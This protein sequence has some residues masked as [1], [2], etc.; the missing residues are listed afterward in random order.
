MK[1]TIVKCTQEMVA[2]RFGEH[3]WSEVLKRAGLPKWRN[4]LNFEDVSDSEFALLI[5]SIAHVTGLSENQV[6]DAHGEYWSTIYAPRVYKRY[7]EKAH[8]ARELLLQLDT[9]HWEMTRSMESAR[10]PNFTYE[11]Q[12][13]SC[14][15]MHYHSP[16]GLVM[17][18]AGLVRGVGK[19]YNENLT[20]K[21]VGNKVFVIFPSDAEPDQSTHSRSVA[22]H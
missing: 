10:P 17:L 7:F 21:V 12:N 19:Y 11:W 4:F 22:R 13:D 9:I 18:M 6:M 8:T 1:G 20:V 2:S 14:L 5:K 15:V 16:R 3:K